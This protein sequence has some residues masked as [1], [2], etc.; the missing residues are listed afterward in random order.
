MKRSASTNRA[1]LRAWTLAVIGVLLTG[2][3]ATNHAAAIPIGPDTYVT[4]WAVYGFELT[5]SYVEHS[6][7]G[8]VI[9][10]VGPN[11]IT[12]G[13]SFAT[14]GTVIGGDAILMAYVDFGT[15][16]VSSVYFGGYPSQPIYVTPESPRASF[17]LAAGGD[18]ETIAPGVGPDFPAGSAPLGAEGQM[19]LGM[20]LLERENQPLTQA[21][22][23]AF[24]FTVRIDEPSSGFIIGPDGTGT[25][26]IAF[27]PGGAD[28]FKAAP[29]LEP[30]TL[31]LLSSGLA[32]LDGMAWRRH[33][34]SRDR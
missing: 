29:V 27:T 7:S 22:G 14:N 15:V 19:I 6:V 1:P 26:S 24:T 12:L 33:R 30:S 5:P 4:G 10:D 32:G 2:F 28:Y 31:L 25:H 8:S 11:P 18:L 21:L 9:T 3:L 16:P 34:T 17:I 20:A 23:V 13:T